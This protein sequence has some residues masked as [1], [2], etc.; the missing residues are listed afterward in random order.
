MF[1]AYFLNSTSASFGTWNYPA[2][3]Y[4]HPFRSTHVKGIEGHLGDLS[5]S[6]DYFSEVVGYKF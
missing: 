1:N 6:S 5:E 4:N 3:E 2:T